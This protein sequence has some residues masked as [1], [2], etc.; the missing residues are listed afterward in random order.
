MNDVRVIACRP[1]AD[2]RLWLRYDD[3]LQGTIHLG[4]LLDIG[5]FRF[6][7]DVDVFLTARPDLETGTVIWPGAG[8][9]LDPEI[10]YRE[11]EASGAHRGPPPGADATF[12]RFM[13]RALEPIKRRR[14]RNG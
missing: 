1:T 6:W 4:N 14:R 5:C 10:L 9:R 3:G 2:Y 13:A 11:L 12:Q 8:V 7:R